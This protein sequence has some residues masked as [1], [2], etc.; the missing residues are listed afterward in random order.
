IP[1]LS[2]SFLNQLLL[3]V[4]NGLLQFITAYWGNQVITESEAIVRTCYEAD[5]IGADVRFQKSLIKIMQRSQKVPRFTVGKITPLSINTFQKKKIVNS[6][7]LFKTEWKLP[8]DSSSVLG[9]IWI[10]DP[11]TTSG[12]RSSLFYGFLSGLTMVPVGGGIPGAENKNASGTYLI[13]NSSAEYGLATF[14]E[15]EGLFVTG[16]AISADH[17]TSGT[18]NEDRTFTTA[19]AVGITNRRSNG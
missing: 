7:I 4:G 18:E 13:A 12:A 16:N 6:L 10:T 19:A 5:F 15:V 1:S 17:P 9:F 14:L 8:Q 3:A 11:F 2:F